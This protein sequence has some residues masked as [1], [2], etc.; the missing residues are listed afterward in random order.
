MSASS[1]H[2][3]FAQDMAFGA[4]LIGEGRTRFRLWGPAQARI[5][6]VVDGGAPIPMQRA[7]DGWHEVEAECGPGA[8]Y[9][10]A[11]PDGA[12]FP[13]PASRAQADDVGGPS[14]VVDPRAYAW[15]TP[16]WRGRPW[17]E[18][19]LYELHVGLF[20]GFAGTM[21]ELPRL[22]E[23][24]VTAVELMPVAEFPGGRNWGYDGVLPYAPDSSYGNPDDLK[25]L[26]D[27]AHELG[28]MVFLDAVYNHFGPDGNWLSRYAPEFFRKGGDTPWGESI[29]VERP[30]VSRFFTD[31][32]LYWLNEYRFDGLR[33]DAVHAIHPTSWLST[34]AATVRAGVEPGRHV[35][36][37]LE[38]E[39]NLARL[40]KGPADRSFDAQ[41]NDDIH[42]VLHVLL[43]GEREHYYAD[44]A[45]QPAVKLARALLD[46]FVYQGEPSPLRKG[47]PRGEPSGHLP[48]T[49]FVAFLQNHDQVGNRA[50]GERLG[51]LAPL[52]ASRAA[53][54][55]LLLSPQIPMLFMGEEYGSRDPFLYFTSHN[56]EL[57]KL[58]RE[59]RQREFAGF[60]Q[61]SDPAKR[62]TIPDPNAL[63]TFERS[64]LTRDGP[65]ALECQACCR[66]LLKLRRTFIMPRLSGAYALDS[67]ALGAA[68]VFARWRLGDGSLL[69]I[70][71]NL[72]PA[73]IP[74]PENV[75][76]PETAP[77]YESKPR[78]AASRHC[79]P[80]STIVWC[81]GLSH[82]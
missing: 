47:Q 26:V 64:R 65:D 28:L 9:L 7:A 12:R 75:P 49:A 22:A 81:E 1:A 10:Y 27:R 68:A 21:A 37:V 74:L 80:Y 44:Y 41:W 73:T 58:V 66:E 35:H 24:G 56:E 29:D 79:P 72:A 23:L 46:G 45:E 11:L 53:M 71:T 30:E 61:F 42:H 36:L 62:A 55:L 40:L 19:V 50:M 31:N 48:P 76:L 8:R 54:A 77:I 14:L 60:S 17:H 52:G 63:A 34:L 39:D 18:A 57:A 6:L 5:D 38:N 20:G 33:F 67:Q 25:R 13:D 70:L 59:G 16:G 82:G 69:A 4:S 51:S 15:R 2:S 43:T 32:A 3:G 78:E